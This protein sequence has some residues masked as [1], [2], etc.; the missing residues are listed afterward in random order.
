[1]L[2]FLLPFLVIVIGCT[3]QVQLCKTDADCS[4]GFACVKDTL[5]N[6]RQPQKC[7]NLNYCEKIISPE[8][9]CGNGV[10]EGKEQ[11][12]CPADC[13]PEQN[14]K[15]TELEQALQQE[16]DRINH[17]QTDSD[18]T[19]TSSSV[20]CVAFYYNK[21]ESLENLRDIES[22]GRNACPI[23]D[24]GVIF[25]TPKCINN[26]CTTTIFVEE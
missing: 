18:C 25:G 7:V 8:P 26:K 6:Q 13:Q 24:C 17:C 1:M 2:L 4:Q 22:K 5:C 20:I 16:I 23:Y 15:C 21:N 9:V 11:A 12:S 3:Q 19:V 10:C 14:K